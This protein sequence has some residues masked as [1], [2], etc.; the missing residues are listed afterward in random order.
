MTRS[1]PQP[2][3]QWDDIVR[4][5]TIGLLSFA[6]FFMWNAGQT[7]VL[8]DYRLDNVEHRVDKLEG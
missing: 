2:R 6:G 3:N 1:Q 7:M 5:V 4:A 8:H